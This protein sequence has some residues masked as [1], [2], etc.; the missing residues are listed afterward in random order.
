MEFTGRLRETCEVVG[1]MLVDH[2]ILG[3]ARAWC[4]MRGEGYFSEG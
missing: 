3:E 2:L 1:L 4:S